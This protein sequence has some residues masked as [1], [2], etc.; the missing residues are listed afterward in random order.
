MKTTITDELLSN[1]YYD[2]RIYDAITESKDGY[3]EITCG[4]HVE[5]I[6]GT[7]GDAGRRLKDLYLQMIATDPDRAKN[8]K[9]KMTFSPINDFARFVERLTS[10]GINRAYDAEKA[11]RHENDC[12]HCGDD[13]TNGYC[14]CGWSE[15][16][17]A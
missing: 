15:D 1:L 8:H 10:Y 2:R 7:R 11:I 9:T 14:Q 12:P 17:Y 4:D 3:W 16:D 13:A 6:T 5:K